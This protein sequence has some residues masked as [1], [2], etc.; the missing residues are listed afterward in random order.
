MHGV[1]IAIE[2]SYKLDRKKLWCE[3]GQSQLLGDVETK[4]QKT[5]GV[6]TRRARGYRPPEF[7]QGGLAPHYFEPCNLILKLGTC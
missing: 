4:V 3:L 2:Y 6:G 1:M 7:T 5:S